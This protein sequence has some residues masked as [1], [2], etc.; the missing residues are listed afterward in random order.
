MAEKNALR[1]NNPT[2]A[3]YKAGD[4]AP[5]EYDDF[6]FFINEELRR[7]QVAFT[8]VEQF[9]ADEIIAG[10]DTTEAEAGPPGPP[11][12][13][14]SPGNVGPQGERGPAG[15][16]GPAG[17]DVGAPI[18]DNVVTRS[19][20]WSSAR[21]VEY[22]EE[23]GGGSG[24]TSVVVGGNPPTSAEQG[25]LWFDDTYTSELYIRYNGLW[26]SVTGGPGQAAVGNA[27]DLNWNDY[28]NNWS[29][30]PVSEALIPGGEVFRYTYT[31]GALFRFVPTP[32][33]PAND[34]FYTSFTNPTLSGLVVARNSLTI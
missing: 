17:E 15:P 16:R 14:G 20:V 28:A 4:A 1:G 23:N 33:D 3:A 10:D 12:P 30:Q 24:G 6:R 21:I 31:N 19:R 9:L 26:V 22:V 32:Y 18:N 8:S 7:I 27:A 2:I 5:E 29:S 11:G 25:D 13:Q 34:A